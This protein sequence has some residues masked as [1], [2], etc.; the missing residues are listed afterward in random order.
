MPLLAAVAPPAMEVNRK[1]VIDAKSFL[2]VEIIGARVVH[3]ELVPATNTHAN[4]IGVRWGTLGYVS[5][6]LRYDGGYIGVFQGNHPSM[7]DY[8]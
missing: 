8:M 4:T 1:V 6:T 7:T 2:T 5:G 3:W